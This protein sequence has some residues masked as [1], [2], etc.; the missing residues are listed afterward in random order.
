MKRLVKGDTIIVL[1]LQREGDRRGRLRL[2]T[3]EGDPVIQTGQQ[4]FCQILEKAGVAAGGVK[5]ARLSLLQ[6]QIAVHENAIRFN[7]KATLLVA[8]QVSA[9]AKLGQ[10]KA[11]AK[12]DKQDEYVGLPL[13]LAG[14]APA[15]SR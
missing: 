15:A 9:C 3:C 7:S 6:I 8:E 5:H 4:A 11:I 2:A 13:G 1:R 12:K 14:T 10:Q